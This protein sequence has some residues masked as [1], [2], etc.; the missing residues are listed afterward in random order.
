MFSP[1]GFGTVKGHPDVDDG[2]GCWRNVV[3]Q[4]GGLLTSRPTLYLNILVS[5]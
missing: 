5:K 1:Q 3:A 4:S 2:V